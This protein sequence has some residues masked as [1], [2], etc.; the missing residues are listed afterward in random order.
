MEKIERKG[1][2]NHCGWC[3]QF[4]GVSTTT[5]VPKEEGLQIDPELARFFQLRNALLSPDGVKLHVLTHQ[6]APC[7]AHD[8]SAVEDGQRPGCTIYEKRPSICQA[9]PIAPEQIE[10]TPCSYWFER[11]VDGEIVERRGGGGSPYP[12]PQRFG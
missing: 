1:E 9:F 10:S 7:S 6:M 4:I 12:T 8:I 2:C 5:L 11:S 3:C